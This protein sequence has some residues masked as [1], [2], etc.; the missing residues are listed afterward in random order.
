MFAGEVR[1]S[2]P[3]A[4]IETFNYVDRNLGIE[5]WRD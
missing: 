2:N 1:G 3:F 4:P 5:G